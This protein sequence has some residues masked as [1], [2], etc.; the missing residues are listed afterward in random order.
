MKV[1][2][3]QPVKHHPHSAKKTLTLNANIQ[4]DGGKEKKSNVIH[5]VGSS[6]PQKPMHSN[7]QRTPQ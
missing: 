6:K 1:V 3:K 5:A 2:K 4:K 7:I